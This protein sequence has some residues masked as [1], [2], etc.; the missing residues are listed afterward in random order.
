MLPSPTPKTASPGRRA[1]VFFNPWNQSIDGHIIYLCFAYQLIWSYNEWFIGVLVLAN[2]IQAHAH[3]G[4]KFWPHRLIVSISTYDINIK[5]IQW[6]KIQLYSTLKCFHYIHATHLHTCMH[7]QADWFDHAGQLGTLISIYH[8]NF[9][10]IEQRIKNLVLHVF[11]RTCMHFQKKWLVP[12]I[13]K[14][15]TIILKSFL[16]IPSVVS[17]NSHGQKSARKG[18]NRVETICSQNFVCGT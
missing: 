1:T 10:W 4:C 17:E 6:R 12:S 18:G 8:I 5:Q 15:Q 11:K 2:Q 13:Y 3:P 9:E 16:L 14:C 7:V